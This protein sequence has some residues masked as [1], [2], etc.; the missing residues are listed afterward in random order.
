MQIF[1]DLLASY[2]L[3]LLFLFS[4]NTGECPHQFIVKLCNQNF[5][6]IWAFGLVSGRCV[7][8]WLVLAGFRGGSTGFRVVSTG[9]GHSAF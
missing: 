6:L 5:N 9:F 1:G 3:K 7:Y 4:Y 2:M 8:G